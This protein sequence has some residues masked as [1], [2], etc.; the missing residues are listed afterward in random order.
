[1]TIPRI[2]KD[3]GKFETW[4]LS[5]LA[6]ILLS[7]GGF[8]TTGSLKAVMTE[9]AHKVEVKDSDQRMERM[10]QDIRWIRNQLERYS[11]SAKKPKVLG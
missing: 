6:A 8:W 1:M 2:R 11:Q 4:A 10:E 7:L 5:L 9:S 3:D